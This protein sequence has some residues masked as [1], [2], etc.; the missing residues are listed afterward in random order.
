M[1]LLTL[2][3]N[4]SG[5]HLKF[6]FFLFLH[7]GFCIF[8]TLHSKQRLSSCS[9]SKIN[10]SVPPWLIFLVFKDILRRSRKKG[11]LKV[12]LSSSKKLWYLLNWKPFESDE[13]C[14]LFRLKSS[15]KIFK[16]LSQ[17]FGHVGKTAWLET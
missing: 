2:I 7:H 8:Q 4:E 9:N 15:Y 17:H 11:V 12:G 5:N 6:S 10:I 3:S 16:F 1:N 14:F 13:N